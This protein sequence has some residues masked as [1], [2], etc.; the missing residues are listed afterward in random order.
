MLCASSTKRLGTEVHTLADAFECALGT[1]SYICIILRDNDIHCN[2]LESN[3]KCAPLKQLGLGKEKK[4]RSINY[5]ARRL[6]CSSPGSL[7]L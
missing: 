4:I 2:F 1:V 5:E 3:A 7:I 6:G